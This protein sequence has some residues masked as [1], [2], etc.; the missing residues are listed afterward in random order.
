MGGV[1]GE[2]D[3]IVRS[4]VGPCGD[5][6]AAEGVGE[7]YVEGFVNSANG[8]EVEFGGDSGGG[9]AELVGAAVACLGGGG[10]GGDGQQG[11]EC[12]NGRS[13]HG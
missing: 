7:V 3:P 4:T 5:T 12:E 13:F 11:Q 2:G 9:L 8:A 10:G 6:F 1:F